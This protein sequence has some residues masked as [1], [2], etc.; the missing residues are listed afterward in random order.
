[1]SFWHCCCGSVP[2]VTLTVTVYGCNGAALSGAS[3]TVTDGTTTHTGTTNGSGQY[4]TPTLYSATWGWTASYSPR[5]NTSS[6][7]NVVVSCPTTNKTDSV[8]LTAATGYVCT[9][10]FTGCALPI[11]TTL[12]LTDSVT[13]V[14]T[15]LTYD[16]V[17]LWWYG[18]STWTGYGGCTGSPCPSRNVKMGY[19]LFFSG[20]PYLS[21]G[22]E[23]NGFG[24]T[25]GCPGSDF[26]YG[27]ASTFSG[28]T[29][30][31]CPPSF[32]WSATG[33]WTTSGG[34]VLGHPYNVG[35]CSNNGT[36]TWTV[37]E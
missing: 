29:S 17:N 1:M 35:A 11:A 10:Q 19:T 23:N 26:T 30:S 31:T 8:T 16:S 28:T 34:I 22:G 32:S 15:T 36:S 13:G 27:F 33:T 6:T 3:V 21:F 25:D 24:F 2:C 9:G 37:T 4:T 7:R 12:Y 18:F 5:F 14:T 20:G